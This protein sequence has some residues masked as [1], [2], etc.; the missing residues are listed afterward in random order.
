MLINHDEYKAMYEV[1]ENLW[2]Y[3]ILHFKTLHVIKKHF[4]NNFSISILDAGCGTG[5]MM[6]QFLNGGY[7]N[8]E[9]F[10]FNDSAVQFSRSRN[11]NVSQKDITKLK[12]KYQPNT[13]DVI[14]CN[15]VLYQFESVQIEKVLLNIETFL[16]PGGIFVSNNNAF[17]IFSG[18]HDIAVGSKGRFVIADF[19]KFLEKTPDLFIKK[20]HYWSF[21]LSPLILLVRIIQRLQLK[22]GKVDLQNI[23][24]DVSMPS[25]PINTF[26]FKLLKFESQYLPKIPFGSSLFIVFQKKQ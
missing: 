19:R 4:E 15:D 14:I 20:F 3:K 8:V 24:S 11:L 18:T 2:W 6:K 21:L 22:M 1:E 25:K 10:D 16:K 7:A 17:S 9:G 23:K 12:N 5:G 26:F 13:F